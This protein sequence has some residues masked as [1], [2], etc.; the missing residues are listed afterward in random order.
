MTRGSQPQEDLGKGVLSRRNSQGRSELGALGEANMARA[1]R[2]RGK[3]VMN[4]IGR[5]SGPH[6]DEYG[7][8]S[9]QQAKPLEG[10][11]HRK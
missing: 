5:S 1:W 2:A 11:K 6:G 8:Y 9:K 4:N 7:F 10:T 3:V